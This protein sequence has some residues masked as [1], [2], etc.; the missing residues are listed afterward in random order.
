MATIK[1]ELATK[2]QRGEKERWQ[3]L[4]VVFENQNGLFAVI[5]SIPVGFSGMVSFFEPKEREQQQNQPAPQRSAQGAP[6]AKK[7]H[8][9]IGDDIPFNFHAKGRIGHCM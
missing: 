3:K 7:S 2:V 5:D 4:G 1:Y 8:D 9:D 6:P